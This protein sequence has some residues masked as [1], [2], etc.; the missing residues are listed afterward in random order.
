MDSG[1]ELFE[2][3][4]LWTEQGYTT[5]QGAH[6][7]LKWLD[8]PNS[9]AAFQALRCVN[10]LGPRGYEDIDE[11]IIHFMDL[12]TTN[13]DFSSP[14]LFWQNVYK[15]WLS[16]LATVMQPQWRQKMT[17]LVGD[18][19]KENESDGLSIEF[20][21]VPPKTYDQMAATETGAGYSTYEERTV[22]S[23][24]LDVLRCTLV[25]NNPKAIVYFMHQ[26]RSKNATRDK[27]Q[28]VKI[29][30]TFHPNCENADGYRE[31][32]LKVVYSSGERSIPGITKSMLMRLVCEI[33]ISLP[34]FQ[35]MKT[36]MSILKTFISGKM[37][38]SLKANATRKSV[39]K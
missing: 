4:E 22:S 37:E 15:F 34:E 39:D 23:S 13:S 36:G 9:I 17:Q 18:F 25:A 8:P 29:E 20:L 26:I 21:L 14:T 24:S 19:N 7:I 38:P 12:V 1:P 3:T 28:L 31:V 11:A 16:H 30:N 33:R 32:I 27:I 5:Q 2:L 6:P 10:A 35:K